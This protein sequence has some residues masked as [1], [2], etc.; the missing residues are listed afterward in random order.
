[1]YNPM[2]ARGLC[3]S[4]TGPLY[5]NETNT[6]DVRT[7]DSIEHTESHPIKVFLTDSLF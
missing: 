4:C 5:V 2:Q 3:L 6:A 1:M 7:Q